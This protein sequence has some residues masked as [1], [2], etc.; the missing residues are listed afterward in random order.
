LPIGAVIGVGL[1][2]KYSIIF[3]VAG[4][5]VG[6]ALTPARRFI[7]TRWFCFGAG[8]ALLVCLPNLVWQIRHDFVSLHFLRYIHARD[9]GEGRAQGFWRAQFTLCANRYA[10][11]CGS[12]VYSGLSSTVVTVRSRGCMWYR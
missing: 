11:S 5:V 12:L 2:T 10:A 1:M 7:A 8:V 6:L 3:Y 4:I 9:V